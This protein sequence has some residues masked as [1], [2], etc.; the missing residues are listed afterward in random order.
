MRGHYKKNNT[1]C[2]K[3]PAVLFLVSS[4][5]FGGAEKHLIALVNNLDLSCFQISLCYLKDN[6]TILH[7]IDRKR[8]DSV[9]CG[10]V[11]H[12]IDFKCIYR[13]SKHIKEKNIRVI[14]C[15]NLYPM[16]YGYLSSAMS[17][18]AC[19]LIEIF[20]TTELGSA[21]TRFQMPVYRL[22]F[23]RFDQAVFVSHNQQ[24]YWLN[25]KS[26]KVA[27]AVT[28]HNGIDPDYYAEIHIKEVALLKNK[29]FSGSDYYVIGMCS[30][31]RPEKRHVDILEAVKALNFKGVKVRLLLIGDGPEKKRI[32][33]R[34]QELD[35]KEQVIIT[36]FQ[37]NVRP[38]IAICDIIVMASAAV[39]TFSIAVLEAMSMGKP[40]VSSDIGGADEQ[41]EHG[42]TGLLFPKGDVEVLTRCLLDMADKK[43]SKKMGVAAALKLR[44]EFTEEGM[45]NKYQRLIESFL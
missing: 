9:F 15:V 16:L 4:L 34:I 43:K 7:Q 45:I 25:D 24:D 17:G 1:T 19:R 41:I 5:C 35:I 26:L 32:E 23:R 40:V 30:A 33:N 44:T 11:Q 37:S 28:I 42:V 3:K 6:K 10:N 13:L 8:L 27:K 29:I 2:E 14:V 22:L 21:Y 31:M 39:E 20:H 12:R 18:K 38:Y 36:G